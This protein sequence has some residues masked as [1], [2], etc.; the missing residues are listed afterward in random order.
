MESGGE[1]E[2]YSLE[3]MVEVLIDR[4]HKSGAKFIMKKRMVQQQHIKQMAGRFIAMG[5]TLFRDI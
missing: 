3:E 5:K 1:Q 4:I 2:I